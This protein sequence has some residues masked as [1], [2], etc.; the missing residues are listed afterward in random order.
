[1]VREGQA[2]GEAVAVNVA[3]GG[4][5]TVNLGAP[6][7]VVNLAAVQVEGARVV[8]RVDVRSTETAT[9]ITR[10]ELKHLPV[11]RSLRGGRTTRARRAGERRNLRRPVVW[12]LLGRKNA[13]Y[14]NGL[15]VT[16]FYTRQGFSSVP[17]AFYREFQVKTGPGSVEFGPGAGGVV[18]TIT[19]SGSNKVEGGVEITFEPAAMRSSADDQYRSEQYQVHALASRDEHRLTKANVWASGPLVRDRLT[20][21]RC[22]SNATSVSATRTIR[23]TPG[24]P[25]YRMTIAVF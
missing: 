16:D 13:V 22:T 1:M 15:N 5:T 3:L 19:R 21:A 7:E 24:R 6:G 25:A 4:N 10:E 17:F 23:A 18:N 20:L 12:R 8:N 9:N 2:V 11:G 14:I